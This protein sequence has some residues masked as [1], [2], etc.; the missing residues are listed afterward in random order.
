MEDKMRLYG[1]I[2]ANAGLAC[3]LVLAALAL[4]TP[5]SVALAQSNASVSRYQTARLTTVAVRRAQAAH[6]GVRQHADHRRPLFGAAELSR[7]WDP[8]A[9]SEVPAARVV[10]RKSGPSVGDSNSIARATANITSDDAGLQQFLAELL[11]FVPQTK[12][13][14]SAPSGANHQNLT[15]TPILS[16]GA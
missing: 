7:Q 5:N 4:A 2:T 11:G 16:N 10:R 15:P 8:R 1:S 9:I 13:P 3:G 12:M 14:I 6:L